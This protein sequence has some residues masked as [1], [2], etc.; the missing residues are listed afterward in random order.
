MSFLSLP[1]FARIHSRLSDVI[2]STASISNN[3]RCNDLSRLP[4]SFFCEPPIS[5]PCSRRFVDPAFADRPTS[6]RATAAQREFETAREISSARCERSIFPLSPFSFSFSYSFH[7][8]KQ[9][10][11][12]MFAFASQRVLSS[13]LKSA[14]CKFSISSRFNSWRVG[15]VGAGPSGLTLARILAVNG[16]SSTVFEREAGESARW[17]GGSLDMKP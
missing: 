11:K 7:L 3:I 5:A 15:I 10:P 6:E 13:S 16:I 2:T 12:G 8:W 9:L 4:S 14:K 17:Q 1:L